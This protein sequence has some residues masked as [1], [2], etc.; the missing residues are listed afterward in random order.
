MPLLPVGPKYLEKNNKNPLKNRKII[1]S[2]L[3]FQNIPSAYKNIIGTV[4]D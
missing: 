3:K 1:A 2:G 4:L